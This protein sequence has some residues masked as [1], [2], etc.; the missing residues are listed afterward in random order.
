MANQ[1][2]DESCAVEGSVAPSLSVNDSGE[3]LKAQADLL[4][5]Q[6]RDLGRYIERNEALE[7]VIKT[8]NDELQ[9]KI[10]RI[11]ELEALCHELTHA[12]KDAENRA[13]T[14]ELLREAANANLRQARKEAAD[15]EQRIAELQKAA[16]G[17]GATP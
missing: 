11:D 12:Q 3:H 1:G 17:R 10:A 4:D 2:V 6:G 8:K 9:V 15:L 5:K 13:I 7:R 16:D 14:S